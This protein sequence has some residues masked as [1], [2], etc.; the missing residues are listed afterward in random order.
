[1]YRKERKYWEPGEKCVNEEISITVK[2]IYTNFQLYIRYAS[3]LLIRYPA[4][5]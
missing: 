4:D 2:Y 5:K 3:F 1:M